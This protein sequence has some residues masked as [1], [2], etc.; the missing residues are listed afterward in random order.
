M[1]YFLGIDAGG[2]KTECVL[3]DETHELARATGGSIKRLRV[4]A[5]EAKRNLAT[6]L[7]QL[8]AI[9]GVPI[10]SVSSTCVGASGASVPLVRDWIFEEMSRLVGGKL[11]VCGDEEIALDAAFQGGPGA[12]IVAGTGSNAIGRTRD[13]RIVNAG[14]WGPALGDEGSGHWIGHQ[15]L[16]AAFRAI[17]EGVPCT[18]VARVEEYWQ[19]SGRAQLVEKANSTPAPDFSKLTELVADCADAGDAVMARVL[20]RGGEELAWMAEMTIRK[21]RELEGESFILPAVAMSGSILNQIARVSQATISRLKRNH[22]EI[23]IVEVP[24]DPTLG[25]LWRARRRASD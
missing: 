23:E 21:L 10:T 14:G 17:D 5:D 7:D 3:A 25:A 24:V 18:L 1:K 6:A 19:L 16:R 9:S 2:T 11:T 13:G 8:V 22:S 15:A 12:L 4:G 20:E